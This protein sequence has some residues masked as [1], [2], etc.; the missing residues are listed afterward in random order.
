MRVAACGEEARLH[1]PDR[2]RDLPRA[3][4][5]RAGA[6]VLIEDH[7]V[8]LTH[9][10]EAVHVGRKQRRDVRA[11][12]RH[13]RQQ[14]A[15]AQPVFR[16]PL[17]VADRLVDVVQVGE[18][19]ARAA[20]GCLGAEVHEPAVVGADPLAPEGIV[21]HGRIPTDQDARAE[22]RRHRIREDHLA[23][24]PLAL[25]VLRALDVVPVLVF[26]AA[27][28]LPLRVAVG[29]APLVE[30]LLV[31]LVEVVAVGLDART[32]VRVR[33]DHHVRLAGHVASWGTQR[34]RRDGRTEPGGVSEPRAARPSPCARGA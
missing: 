3:V 4:V 33:G 10:V 34:Y 27:D 19:D 29:A 31:L 32:R 18:A 20:L 9:R 21:L 17:D 7:V 1:E 8:V 22:E 13:V 23:G 14:H 15:A 6:A 12:G 24:D 30:Q 16:N 25:H 28:V 11:V 2:Q 5:G 26:L